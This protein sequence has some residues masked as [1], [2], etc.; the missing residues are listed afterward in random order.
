MASALDHA[1]K[2]YT[3]MSEGL[4]PATKRIRRSNQPVNRKLCIF[5][6]NETDETD[7]CFQ[8]VDLTQQIHE[9]AVALGEERIVALL[10]EGD[11]V[12]I[13]ARYHRNCYT[14]FNRR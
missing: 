10:A 1:K 9:R 2:C 6:G 14:G 4:V 5:C 3:H 7:H 12:A 13:E 11:L 8:K